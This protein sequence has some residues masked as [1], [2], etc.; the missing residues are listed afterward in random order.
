MRGTRHLTNVVVFTFHLHA[1]QGR[2]TQG[3]TLKVE[4][5]AFIASLKIIAV[6]NSNRDQ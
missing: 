5:I 6:T 1:N 4:V 3:T 2:S